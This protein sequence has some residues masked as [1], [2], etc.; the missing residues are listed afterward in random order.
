MAPEQIAA[1]AVK[2]SPGILKIQHLKI[3]LLIPTRW[4]GCTEPAVARLQFP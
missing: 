1:M 4:V 3:I 2:L